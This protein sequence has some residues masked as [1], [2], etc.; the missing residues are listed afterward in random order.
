MSQ[1]GVVV[2]PGTGRVAGVVAVDQVDAAGDGPNILH[3]GG[4]IQ[5]GGVRVAGVQAEP[6]VAQ[7]VGAVEGGPQVADGFEV[8]HHRFL[9]ARGVLDQDR[10]LQVEAVDA[11]APVVVALLLVLV[12]G[13]VPAVDDHPARPDP[14]G[15]VDGLLQQFPRRDA[16]AIVGGGDVYDVR[17]VHVEPDP[18]VGGL[19]PQGGGPVAGDCGFP[20][21]LRVTE[22][23]LGDVRPQGDGL[24]NR[25]IRVNMSTDQ[26]GPSLGGGIVEEDFGD[27]VKNFVACTVQNLSRCRVGGGV[28]VRRRE[29]LLG[30]VAVPFVSGG[31][32]GCSFVG[33]VSDPTASA[34]ASVK[35]RRSTVVI[36]PPEGW[37]LYYPPERIVGPIARVIRFAHPGDEEE[38]IAVTVFD[39]DDEEADVVAYMNEW[40]VRE[41]ARRY[42]DVEFLGSRYLGGE[43]AA[44]ASFTRKTDKGVS[45]AVLNLRTLCRRF[46][47]QVGYQKA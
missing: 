28:I 23:H 1:R 3:H 9:A 37:Q 43:L 31:V 42:P 46:A 39:P 35:G 8:S 14:G 12:G 26:H 21:R 47:R 41:G 29:V 38:G 30:L 4:Q 16:D 25:G 10:H 20:P 40:V 22:G 13:D 17:G 45:Y 36:E 32:G 6:D 15:R 18:G 27:V 24:R 44:G 7:V 2:A 33:P 19:R 11:L 34:M 5:A